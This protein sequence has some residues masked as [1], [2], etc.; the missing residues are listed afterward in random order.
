MRKFAFFVAF[1][2]L[3]FYGFSQQKTSS[4]L[5]KISGKDVVA[6]SYIYGTIH[7]MCPKDIIVSDT[8]RKAFNQTKKLYLELDMDD[9]SILLKTMQYMKMPGD[10]TLKDL[11]NKSTYDSV[12]A[13]FAHISAVPFTMVSFMRP[14]L[15]MSLVYPSLLGC[16]GAEAWEQKFMEM[17]KTNKE[18]IEGL[19]P[20]EDQIKVFTT[21]PLK[22]QADMLAETLLHTDSL[23]KSFDSLLTAYKN[24]DLN[25]L[26]KLMNE[27][28]DE[29]KYQDLMLNS[30]NKNWIP[31]IEKQ[32]KLQPVFIAVGAGH[33]AGD[34]G[35]L[36]L[37][38]KDGYTV[39]PVVY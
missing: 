18:D 4:L 29:A 31:V 26:A 24:K 25:Q 3:C 17:A 2:L 38:K 6:P 23:Q 21:I 35:V 30:R 15:A 34:D 19:E 10:T 39:E 11:L 27:D 8:L 9:P 32:I 14:M 37:L 5:W 1:M 12:A 33:L 28:P 7:L 16:E 22:E 36:S 20:V 13:S